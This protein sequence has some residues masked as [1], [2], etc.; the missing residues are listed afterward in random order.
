M[1][2]SADD[3]FALLELY[4]RYNHAIDSKDGVAYANCFTDDA[5]FG[6]SNT[7]L[8]V[9]GREALIK[10][11]SRPELGDTLHATANFVFE[12]AKEGAR[13]K[14]SVILFRRGSDGRWKIV[15][16]GTYDDRLVRADGGWRFRSRL[17]EVRPGV[18]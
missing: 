18:E 17:V 2:L 12:A 10:H 7:A 16:A 9:T 11:G 13:G 3:R 5:T 15:V 14:A 4:A 1:E 6:H 8:R